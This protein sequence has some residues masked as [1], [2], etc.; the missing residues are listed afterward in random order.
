MNRDRLREIARAEGIRDD[1]YSFDGGLPSEQ[2]VLAV[3][4]GGW[5]VY[6]SER[7][8]RTGLRHFDTEDEACHHMLD[9]LLRD[10]TNREDWGAS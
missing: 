1:A 7:G 5:F 2:L 4:E 9:S 6:Y 8:L 3:T 10:P